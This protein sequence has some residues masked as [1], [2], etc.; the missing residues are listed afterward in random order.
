MGTRPQTMYGLA[1]SPVSLSAWMINHDADSYQ[2][3]ARSRGT[4][5]AT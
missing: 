4:L 2:D 5:S 3:I 1:D